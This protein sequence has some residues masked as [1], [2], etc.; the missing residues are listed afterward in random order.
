L[1]TRRALLPQ[2]FEKV[3]RQSSETFVVKAKGEKAR[4]RTEVRREP[5]SPTTQIHERCSRLQQ[6]EV[7]GVGSE[8]IIFSYDAED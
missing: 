3:S 5:F 4:R 6:K 1:A 7:F 8:F 2:I